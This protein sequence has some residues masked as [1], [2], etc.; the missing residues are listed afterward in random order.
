M[1]DKRL[2][3]LGADCVCGDLILDRV[4]VGHYR[5]GQ[6][7]VTPEGAEV[8]EADKAKPAAKP[9]AAPAPAQTKPAT[10][11]PRAAKD[12]PAEAPA[13]AAD[14]GTDDAGTDPVDD[15]T[16]GLDDLLGK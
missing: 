11:A 15:L 5:N 3:E 14:A 1:S 4:T 8:L 16:A 6:F 2:R 12:K 13:P 10:R 7:V 9:A